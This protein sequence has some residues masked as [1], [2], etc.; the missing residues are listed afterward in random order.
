MKYAAFDGR[1]NRTGPNS[2]T[3]SQLVRYSDF[4]GTRIVAT[5][6]QRIVAHIVELSQF[7]GVRRREQF[8]FELA[9]VMS[10][11]WE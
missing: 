1:M 8:V 9:C 2:L 6:S 10:C 5:F 7:V 11:H 4:F 3:W